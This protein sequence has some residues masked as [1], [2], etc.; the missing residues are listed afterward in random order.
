MLKLLQYKEGVKMK[1]TYLI[2]SLLFIFFLFTSCHK[3]TSAKKVPG[4]NPP[5]KTENKNLPEVSGS[6]TARW[7]DE[8]KAIV[9]FWEAGKRVEKYIIN[10][11]GNGGYFYY[12]TAVTAGI[13]TFEDKNYEDG[14]V[15]QYEVTAENSYGTS[16]YGLS[17]T[18]T[19]PDEFPPDT[20]IDSAPPEITISTTAEFKFHGEDK[21][22]GSATIAKFECQV[23]NGDWEE[24]SSP[25]K[26]TDLE[27]NQ[28]YTFRVRAYD[29]AGNV[30]PTPAEYQWKISGTTWK[31]ISTGSDFH[32]GIT[33][34]GD[35]YCWG[36]NDH[37][38]IGVGDN[39]N[40]YYPVQVAP[41]SKWV[42]V[43]CGEY[44]TCGIKTDGTLW[45]WGAN[46]VGQLGIGNRTYSQT[47][48]V[49]VGDD[50]EW[51][52]VS[53]G[54]GDTC[55]IKSDG[56]LY[57][58]G[59][60]YYGQLGLIKYA[61]SITDLPTKVGDN[62]LHI[63][64]RDST[65]CGVKTDLSLYCWGYNA[66]G[67]TG[68]NQHASE[69]TQPTEVYN[70]FKDWSKISVGGEHNCGIRADGSLYCWGDG[71]SGEVGTGSRGIYYIPQKV[72]G[73]FKWVDVSTGSFHTCGLDT[74]G[75]LHCRGWNYK[76]CFG[77][78][79]E[80]SY[81]SPVTIFP[82]TKFLSISTDGST[83]GITQ[84]GSLYCWGWN[85]YGQVGV[86]VIS[87][88]LTPVPVTE[89]I[90]SLDS[91]YHHNIAVTEDYTILIWGENNEWTLG[92][93]DN[94]TGENA[95]VVA[96]YSGFV[97]ISTSWTHSCGIKEDGT[98]WCWG[99][100]SHGA[101]GTGSWDVESS[102][103]K[104][105]DDHWKDITTGN[106]FTCGIKSDGT[107]W[108]W[109][110]NSSGELGISDTSSNHQDAPVQVGTE[111]N[112]KKVKAGYH[113]AC[114]MKNDNTLWCWGDNS[115]GE[116]GAD[117]SISKVTAPVEVSGTTWRKFTTGWYYACAI[118]SDNTLWCW[119]KDYVNN[120][121][122]KPV[123][124]G[125]DND[126]NKLF[127]GALHT[128]AIKVDGTL[129]CW[130]RNYY[131]QLGTGDKNNR[132]LPA[133]VGTDS[134]WISGAAGQSHTCAFKSNGQLYCWGDDEY[135]AVGANKFFPY[136]DKMWLVEPLLFKSSP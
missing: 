134:D 12:L 98:L 49:Q 31:L 105:S 82:E 13:T 103:V 58:W 44:H 62:W 8:K 116:V 16:I 108:C 91:G 87:T 51:V 14:I 88:Y 63:S 81:Y 78:H 22:H 84:N 1:K 129:W 121:G 43:S 80:K 85:G 41:G 37:G 4:K 36:K 64:T 79:I 66:Y 107:L 72:I 9:V 101:L 95:P 69:V 132:R 96:P 34:D 20:F 26:V 25:Y 113:F 133:Q 54:D 120:Y 118:S 86:N 23:N 11:R 21:F 126:W 123:Q 128:C 125:N 111:N 5:G 122:K 104:I 119:G 55:A 130:G 117:L 114:G 77:I 6:V 71:Q 47:T 27:L 30:D 109:G 46:F 99:K 93:G 50:S 90:V 28:T 102:P 136:A 3:K 115:D 53:A 61:N 73:N 68:T 38:E 83:C 106:E 24:C 67:E 124:I 57:C 92:T 76:K 59:S 17:N 35:L 110:D 33:T 18:V 94:N 39:A 32:C 15:Y 135:G 89:S 75:P 97:T 29:K 131:G 45:C 7:D 2:F 70:D 65:T 19:V 48:P 60:G 100:G 40:H 112:W 42:D 52:E 56:T 74:S 10:R 127:A